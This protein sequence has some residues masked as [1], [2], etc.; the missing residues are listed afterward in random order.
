MLTLYMSFIDDD[1]HRRLFKQIYQNYRR[2]MFLMA[3][4]VLSNDTYA[5]D[6]VHDVFL[7][8]AKKHMPMISRIQS[9]IDLRNYLLKATKNAALDH[10]R[11][12]RHERISVDA[13]HEKNLTDAVEMSDNEFV[14]K[15]CNSIEYDRIVTAISSLKD[16][17]REALYYHFVLEMSVPEVAKLLNCKV[18]TVKQR[19]IRG[20]KL[21]NE[22]LFGEE[23]KNGRQ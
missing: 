11:K 5:E 12:H 17:Y 16:I 3:R 9:D 7:R 19:L 15:I 4:S 1:A 13:D 2:Q 10:L 22:K 20:K 14:D 6:V 8:I 18:A 21:L 23:S